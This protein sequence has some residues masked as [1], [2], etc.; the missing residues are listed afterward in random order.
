MRP[1]VIEMPVEALVCRTQVR[2][3]FDE[4]KLAGLAQSIKACG[5]LQP[6]LARPDF[7]VVDGERRLRAAKLAGL[8][9]VPVL[10]EEDG[11]QAGEIMLRQLV[12]NC[13]REDLTP[14]EKA[15]AIDGLMHESNWSAGHAAAKLGLSPAM[16]SKLLTLLLLPEPVQQQV[17][18][19]QIPLSSAYEIA[20]IEDAAER[21]RLT[22]V[23]ASGRLS[24]DRLGA[25]AKVRRKKPQPP[26]RKKPRT[27]QNSRVRL[28]FGSG[29]A[30]TIAGPA[31]T[32]HTLI[33][34][35]ESIIGKAKSL[36]AQ[37][38]EWADA[39]QALR[40]SSI[41]TEATR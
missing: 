18:R 16:V 36:Q 10:I 13:Q 26:Q 39:V 33:G 3:A 38:T 6:I 5:V 4:E 32:L 14:I 20:K 34:W 25:E 41:A 21:E 7:L 9:T 11:L 23:V 8:L 17:Q 35:L 22:A 28:P 31:L 37:G 29:H 19:G 15:R 30:L 12:S 24:R 27:R 2:E 1:E 40:A